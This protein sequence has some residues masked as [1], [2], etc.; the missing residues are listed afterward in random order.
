MARI[1][2]VD[3]EPSIRLF[4]SAV[5]ADEGHEVVEAPSG[6]DAL[7]LLDVETP[8]LVILDIRLGTCNGLELLQQIASHPAHVPVIILTAYASFQDDYT[9]WLAE[10]YVLKSSDPTEFLA[11]VHRIL[12]RRQRRSPDVPSQ[13]GRT[14]SP[15]A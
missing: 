6:P 7:R 1:L 13:P 5:L 14:L 15:F 12:D 10:S 11:E 4:Y 8:D 9:T 3:D 2:L